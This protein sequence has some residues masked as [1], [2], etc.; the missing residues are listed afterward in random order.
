VDWTATGVSH[1]SGNFKFQSGNQTVNIV[2][3]STFSD[4]N[5]SGSVVGT[6]LVAPTGFLNVAHQSVIIH[7]SN[8]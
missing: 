7:I 4:A 6:D 3:T 1:T 5:I 8:E 2:G